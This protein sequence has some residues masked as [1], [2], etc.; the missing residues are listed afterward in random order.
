MMVAFSYREA[1]DKSCRS[2]RWTTAFSLSLL[3]LFLPGT[4]FADPPQ[5]LTLTEGIR[6]TLKNHPALK[7]A[8][9]A[10]NAADEAVREARGGFLPRIDLSETFNRTTGPGE[11]FW[12]EL[13]QERFSLSDF[14]ATNPN[15]PDAISNYNTQV[16]LV[17]PLYTGGKL[18]AGYQISKLQRGAVEKKREQTRQQVIR[19][20][21]TAY[22]RALLAG[23]YVK[24][25][26]KA[27][28]AVEAHVK[29]ARDLLEQGMVLRSDLLRAQV[30]L[31]EVESRLITAKNQR[32]LAL[33]N[34]N[35]IMGVDQGRDYQLVDQEK[36]TPSP[37]EEE[38][39]QLIREA[40]AHRPDLAGLKRMKEAAE[41]GVTV[42][43]SAFLP[44]INLVARYDRNDR[45]FLGS[46]GEYWSVMAVA[47]INLFEGLSGR[48]RV[49]RA[50]ADAARMSSLVTRAEEGIEM[51]VRKAYLN[52][53]E[54]GARLE[55]AR[56]TVAMSEAGM[57]IVEDRYRNGMGR[58]TELLD[59]EASLTRARTDEA[60]ARYDLNLS[61]THLDFALG[62]L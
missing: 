62:R 21:T 53:K 24:V 44:H 51:E 40:E 32:K 7:A 57:K 31:S 36:T 47:G 34:L 16:T 29:M 28:A 22:Y 50:R 41:K 8:G 25:A 12:T 5:T 20:F 4:L 10:L 58:I 56:R 37:P 18:S 17:Q 39:P 15:D 38:L 33:A 14:A 45:D 55:V 6:T 49:R 46:D 9:Y 19:E 43:R 59:T 60:R 1:D 54:A 3:L 23:R 13:S 27:K 11:V 42:A 61:R 2:Y 30:R 35:R 48:A 52:M 26:E